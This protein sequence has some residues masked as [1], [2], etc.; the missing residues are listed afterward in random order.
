MI[1]YPR[2]CVLTHPA[3]V[4]ERIRTSRRIFDVTPDD[5]Q[6]LMVKTRGEA[7]QATHISVV[8]DWFQELRAR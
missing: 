2:R 7:M 6:F 5:R 3:V 1:G 8:L 4:T